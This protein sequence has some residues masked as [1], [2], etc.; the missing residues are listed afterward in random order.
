[1]RYGV[2]VE[3][4]VAGE[5]DERGRVVSW[6]VSGRRDGEVVRWKTRN[7]VVAVGGRG[8]IPFSLQSSEIEGR[9]FHSS[10]YAHRITGIEKEKV[11]GRK[12]RFVVIGS[13]QSAAEIF[14]DLWDR[15]PDADVKLIIKG[16]S[17]RPSDDSPLFVFPFLSS[18]SFL[19]SILSA[20]NQFIKL[21]ANANSVN[22]IFNPTHTSTIFSL[23]PS[24]REKAISLDRGTNYGV[25]RLELLEHLYE[26]MYMQRLTHPDEQTWRCQILPNRIIVSASLRKS[27]IDDAGEVVRLKLSTSEE[28][29]VDYIFAATGYVRDVHEKILAETRDLL[30]STNSSASSC[31]EE[32]KGGKFEVGRNYKVMFDGEKVD[33]ERAG[34]WLQGCCEGSHGLSDTLLS[35]LAVRGGEVV[36]S[37][38]GDGIGKDERVEKVEDRV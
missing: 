31:S 15:F 2:T 12:L 17:L 7:V 32:K 30:P 37:I 6:V 19:T 21:L 33:S 13:G 23:P 22:E 25:V 20:Q 34:V 28:M 1:M 38:F 9:V 10:E 26:K 16:Q 35:V 5:K 36:E 8:V 14:N 24:Q 11:K 27:S 4:V 3:G 18:P 29:E